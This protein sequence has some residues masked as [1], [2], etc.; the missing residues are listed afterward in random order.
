[1]S[2]P[3]GGHCTFNYGTQI[4]VLGGLNLQGYLSSQLEK[5]ELDRG[6]ARQLFDQYQMKAKFNPGMIQ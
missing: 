1:M 3:R 4:L 2:K 6:V 5:C